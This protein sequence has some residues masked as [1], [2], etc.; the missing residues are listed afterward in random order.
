MKQRTYKSVLSGLFLALALL[1]PFLTASNR[2]IGNMLLP[3]HIPVLLCGFIC[4]P[5]WGSAVGL[6]APLLRSL[7][8]GM[9]QMFPTAVAMAAELAT[10]GLV[11]GLLYSINRKRILGLYLS[12]TAAMLAGRLV[13]GAVSLLLYGLS[14]S[15]FG[16]AAFV[17]G[18]FIN[19]VP[20][21]I[22][23][24][25]AVPPLVILAGKYIKTK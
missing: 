1:L 7:A 11:S 2:E 25:I 10:Y 4:G 8:F 19:A 3:M 17:S 16:W 5:F 22:I 13:W 15:P 20:G 24:F 21:I 14:S 12:L 23:Q 6:A 9:P 18:A